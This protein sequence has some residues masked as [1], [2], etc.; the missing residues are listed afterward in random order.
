M[1]A[2]AK[3]LTKLVK[4]NSIQDR[5]KELQKEG[6]LPVWGNFDETHRVFNI[7]WELN[8]SCNYKEEEIDRLCHSIG[9]STKA[10]QIDVTLCGDDPIHSPKFDFICD[11][12]VSHGMNLIIE[13]NGD[14]PTEW[15]KERLHKFKAI[16]LMYH[17]NTNNDHYT[18]VVNL[19]VENNVDITCRVLMLKECFDLL[20][21]VYTKFKDSINCDVEMMPIFGTKYTEDQ[22][23]CILNQNAS[24]ETLELIKTSL[25]QNKWVG[26]KCYAGIDSIVID[27]HG[28][29][30]TSWCSSKEEI[31]SIYSE[32]IL[33]CMSDREPI[34]C[35]SF[36]VCQHYADQQA[37][38]EKWDH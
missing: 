35:K 3:T 33:E 2:S 38:K 34:R 19:L 29:I 30:F 37:R 7:N 27:L 14:K 23:D 5:L 13:S 22:L 8:S 15:W 6:L 20:V 31:C 9:Q 32:D 36:H 26:K 11:S 21:D 12:I 18:N 1:A 4:R 17:S 16:A 28:T 10:V 25:E 24:L